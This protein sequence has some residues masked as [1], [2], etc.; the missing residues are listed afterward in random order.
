MYLLVTCHKQSLWLADKI[1]KKENKGTC[2]A[3]GVTT[4]KK[5]WTFRKQIQNE[6]KSHCKY[7]QSENQMLKHQVS[8]M[9]K[10]NI[11]N[12]NNYFISIIIRFSTFRHRTMFYRA[13]NKFKRGVRIKLIII[14]SR[15][16][17]LKRA[18]DHVKEVPSIKFFC[19]NINSR[20]KEK[21]MM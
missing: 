19:A 2:P 17:L 12:P 14:K 4:D 13:K 18:N 7:L 6:I 15:Y 11:S 21:L 5:F 3:R 8:E 20:L 10:L 1:T 9:T 16:D